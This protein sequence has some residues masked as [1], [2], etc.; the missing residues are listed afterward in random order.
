MIRIINQNGVTIIDGQVIKEKESGK[1]V[2]INEKRC[3]KATN[4]D[5]ILIDTSFIDVNIKAVDSGLIEANA[6][7]QIGGYKGDEKLK[8]DFKVRNRQLMI[9]I[10]FDGC[11]HYSNLQINIHIPRKLFDEISINTVSADVKLSGAIS[12]KLLK[13]KTS[14]G[15]VWI[16]SGVVVEKIEVGSTSGDVKSEMN[17]TG[18]KIRCTSGDIKL[19]MNAKND[20]NADIS[21]TSGDIKMKFHNF[22][23]LR[24][25]PHTI[26]GDVKNEYVESGKYIGDFTVATV[27]GDIRVM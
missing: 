2:K 3:E 8:F 22:K 16:T 25:L 1:K 21:T 14:S 27:T 13:I 17:F 10:N 5:K 24:L 20:V 26:C 23:K 12:T 11:C 18:A 6:I 9:S 15:D 19:E 7:G 4:I